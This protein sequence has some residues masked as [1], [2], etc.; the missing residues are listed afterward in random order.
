MDGSE[1]GAREGGEED[2]GEETNAGA[3]AEGV[4]GRG[5]SVGDAASSSLSKICLQ[6]LQKPRHAEQNAEDAFC[7]T[8]HFPVSAHVSGAMVLSVLLNLKLLS[9]VSLPSEAGRDPLR[10]LLLMSR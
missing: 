8:E 4:A 3:A 9:P 2:G 7:L 1:D 10:E 6:L 5:G